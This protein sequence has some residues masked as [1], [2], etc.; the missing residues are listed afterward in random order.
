MGD[1]EVSFRIDQDVVGIRDGA[2]G[3]GHPVG[4]IAADPGAG[5][6]GDNP[7]RC[8]LPDP[9]VV[10]VGYVEVAGGVERE[11][12]WVVDASVL[13]GA[14][15]AGIPGGAGPGDRADRPGR[16]D[17][18]DAMVPGIGNVEVPSRVEGEPHRVPDRGG[19]GEAAVSGIAPG[20]ISDH[21]GYNARVDVDLADAM[22]AAVGEV[23][24]AGS[25]LRHP[26]AEKRSQPRLGGRAVVVDVLAGYGDDVARLERRGLGPGRRGREQKQRDREQVEEYY[27]YPLRHATLLESITLI[28]KLQS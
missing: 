3:G 19:G 16:G 1:E 23:D 9:V 20:T 13:G 21:G 5:N 6:G 7:A 15:V 14:L 12:T 2:R 28:S 17:L 8:H 26:T 27:L 24:V 22:V 18:A 4:G 25:V 10:A 11:A